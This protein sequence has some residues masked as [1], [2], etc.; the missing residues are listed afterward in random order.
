MNNFGRVVREGQLP[1]L[2]NTLKSL[3]PRLTDLRSIP[4]N[5]Q[6]M[7][8]GECES[9]WLP[10]KLMGEGVNRVCHIVVSLMSGHDGYLFL[11]EIE[12]GVHFSAQRDIWTA[13]GAAAKESGVQIFATT[14]S[15][16][17]IRAAYDAFAEDNRL[18]EFRYHRLDRHPDSGDI[19]A[20]TYNEFGIESAMST[21]WEIR[22]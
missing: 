6:Q 2:V 22:G 19:K 11:D 9:G 3:E 17:M 1:K 18:E 13:V 8:W 21:N 12:N 20:V 14:H 16:E 15:L 5:G 7:I 10:I 4:S